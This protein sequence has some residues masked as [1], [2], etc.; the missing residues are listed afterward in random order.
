M[1]NLSGENVHRGDPAYA[2]LY[3]A[4]K[5]RGS[6]LN[7]E[8]PDWHVRDPLHETL[9]VEDQ[10][11]WIR[12]AD[13]VLDFRIPDAR[14]PL[15]HDLDALSQ[16]ALASPLQKHQW[17]SNAEGWALQAWTWKPATAE[18]PPADATTVA[19]FTD[20]DGFRFA[21]IVSLDK[22]AKSPRLA[23]GRLAILLP[24]MVRV[25]EAIPDYYRLRGRTPAAAA[26]EPLMMGTH[27]RLPAD[28]AQ[29]AADAPAA[30]SKATGHFAYDLEALRD[31]VRDPDAW[32]AGLPN[33]RTHTFN[34]PYRP[35][36]AA[37]V[38][39]SWAC[40][41]TTSYKDAEPWAAGGLDAHEAASWQALNDRDVPSAGPGPDGP[42]RLHQWDHDSILEWFA[43]VGGGQK[44]RELA[45]LFRSHD[46]TPDQVGRWVGMLDTVTPHSLGDHINLFEGAGWDE[47][48]VRSVLSALY[49]ANHARR[50]DKAWERVI[51]GV[52]AVAD[53]LF[54]P[55]ERA[56]A[57]LEAGIGR[58]EAS[59]F[60]AT[61][62]APDND[63]LTMMAAFNPQSVFV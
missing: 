40:A 37:R 36:A 3:S 11:G 47:T 27:L 39:L 50:G 28:L 56:V 42:P 20:P 45:D 34:G 59:A 30:S 63:T 49:R 44:R 53:W 12:W 41:G 55:A 25:F 54:V 58:K 23:A 32:F 16:P 10:P 33:W 1:N 9:P 15:P 8:V 38:L 43:A 24:S 22:P 7:P 2:R 6:A 52:D 21:F 35:I 26:T 13:V 4:T 29:Q 19:R 46:L 62:Q 5:N 17:Y 48:G 60:E 14:T 18:G 31:A 57:Y 51:V 61:G